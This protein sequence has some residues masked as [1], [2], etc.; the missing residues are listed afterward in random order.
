[1]AQ[2]QDT[3]H[4][5]TLRTYW[6]ENKAFPSLAKVADLLGMSSTGS[7]FELVGRMEA[8]GYLSRTSGR[9]APGPSFF[10]YPVLGTVRAGLP[11]PASQDGAFDH[12]SVEDLLIREPNKTAMCHIRGD[13]MRDAGLLDG[14]VVVVET[15][16]LAEPGDIVVAAVDGELT[17]KTLRRDAAGFYL[18]PANSAFEVIRPL[19][20]L[21]IL[22]LV[23]GSFRTFKHRR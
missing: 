20:D 19:T 18:E 13:S 22:G 1:M 12:I 6:R 4:L 3:K 10:A 5:A 16:S 8:S 23:V 11:Q 15:H 9:L 2:Q 7:A 21:E 17:V 14:D